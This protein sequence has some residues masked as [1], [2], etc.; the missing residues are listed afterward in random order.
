MDSIDEKRTFIDKPENVIVFNEFIHSA[1]KLIVQE[2]L[3]NKDEVDDVK[4]LNYMTAD[5]QVFASDGGNILQQ[6]DVK[7]LLNLS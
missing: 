1:F 2:N 5:M 7:S 3:L 4:D 6:I